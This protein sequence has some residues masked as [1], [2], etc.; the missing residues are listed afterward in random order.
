MTERQ[1]RR[2]NADS[3]SAGPIGR[4]ARTSRGG[5]QW[6][7]A[8]LQ[9]LWSS[10]LV[11]ALMQGCAIVPG[12]DAYSLRTSGTSSVELPVLTPDGEVPTR[13]DV[14]E[15]DARLI[16]EKQKS[17]QFD[18]SAEYTAAPRIGHA[19][20][21]IGSGDVLNI[22]VWGHPELTIPMG[23]FRS[24]DEAGT[25]V[26]ENGTIFFPY[27]GVVEVAG[28]TIPEVR[29]LLTEELARV[30]EDVQLEVRMAAFRSKRVYVVGEVEEP[31]I[32]AITDV[33]MTVVEAI[34]RAGGLTEDA[35]ESRV[36]LNRQGSASRIDLLALYERG[37]LS[38]NVL[39]RDGD[40][41]NVPDNDLNKV[42]LLG[43]IRSPGTYRIE[44]GR[45]TLA[46][47][48]SDAGNINMGLANP[49]QIFVV[50][51]GPTPE[52]FHLSAKEPDALL[53]AEG[54]PLQRRDIVYVDTADL[55][56]WNKFISNLLPTRNFFELDTALQ[57]GGQVTR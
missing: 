10:V 1:S 39:L 8:Q 21:R 22:I 19:D 46:E 25:V 24:A 6:R 51:G 28:L 18:A 35:D 41:V 11:A 26:S 34:N 20:Y 47:A 3:Y 14:Q 38:E 52:I 27:A 54:F 49:Y 53:L 9:V 36:L 43:E 40:I 33:P 42:Y 55:A 32:Y 7:G 56:R 4:A 57:E 23:E 12:Y 37:D 16:I 5:G 2:A 15:I 29:A 13:I 44:K 17:Q 45:L 30:I 31:G 48:L 50:R